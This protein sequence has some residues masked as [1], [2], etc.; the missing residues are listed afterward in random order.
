L[1]N[2]QMSLYY[3]ID[4]LI[5]KKFD[6]L[7]PDILSILTRTLMDLDDRIKEFNKMNKTRE[8]FRVDYN[9]LRKEREK[10]REVESLK[11]K[12]IMKECKVHGFL[13]L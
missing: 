10:L 12:T 9:R 4:N 8:M 2:K 6:E 5:N 1:F 7:D 13:D 11:L 3:K